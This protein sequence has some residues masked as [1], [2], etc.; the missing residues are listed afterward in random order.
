MIIYYKRITT[1]HK[2]PDNDQKDEDYVVFSKSLK[3]FNKH[4]ID[5]ITFN[6]DSSL[7]E[8]EKFLKDYLNVKKI[9]VKKI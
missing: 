5:G 3:K 4:I 6:P 1:Y 7:Q 2:Y 9:T 8:K